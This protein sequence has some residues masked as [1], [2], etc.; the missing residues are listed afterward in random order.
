[1]DFQQY[2]SYGFSDPMTANPNQDW[3]KEIL[4]PFEKA[5]L[6]TRKDDSET[7]VGKV[8]ERNGLNDRVRWD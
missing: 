8:V 3:A 1:M 7:K 5:L 6:L 2:V 4:L